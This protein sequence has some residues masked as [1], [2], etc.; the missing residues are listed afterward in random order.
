MTKEEFNLSEK[1]NDYGYNDDGT[2][3]SDILEVKDVKEFIRLLK[4][5][6][7]FKRGGLNRIMKTTKD[8]ELKQQ[9]IGRDAE[10]DDMEKFLFKLA[11][12]KLK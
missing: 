7:W 6:M 12:E 9:I 10:L 4:E 2:P 8:E 11:G 3:D 5:E 1:I